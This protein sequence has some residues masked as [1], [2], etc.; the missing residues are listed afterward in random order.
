MKD[1]AASAASGM[2]TVFVSERI[3]FVKVSELLINDYL[4][5]VNDKE[6]VRR[7]I[8]A[9]PAESEFTHENEVV[10]VRRSLEENKQVFSMVEKQSG[11]FIGNIELMDFNGSEAELGIALTAAM[12]D[13][14]YG[15]E[16]IK[17]LIAYGAEKLGLKKLR[18]RTRPW[19]ARARH[20]YEK[21]GFCEIRRT[22]DDIYM[23]TVVE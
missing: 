13:K 15:T 21:C 7:F 23:E 22:K 10:W 20:V 17:A 14:G 16:A 6:H 4:V 11:R 9:A 3:N 12:Q 8:S 5:M 1:Q 2:E 19:N 18:L